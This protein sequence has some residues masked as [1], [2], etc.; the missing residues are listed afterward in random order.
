MS[1]IKLVAG[2]IREV[3]ERQV[4]VW[5]KSFGPHNKLQIMVEAEV[6]VGHTETKCIGTIE[7]EGGNKLKFDFGSS[8][9]SRE[10]TDDNSNNINILRIK[11]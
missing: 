6:G 10:Y 4:N 2:E 11:I 7:P 3:G 8:V 5:I 9:A 1:K